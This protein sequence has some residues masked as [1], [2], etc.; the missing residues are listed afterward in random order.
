MSTEPGFIFST[1][2][3]PDSAAPTTFFAYI[4]KPLRVQQ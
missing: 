3:E 1:S 2:S 4:Y